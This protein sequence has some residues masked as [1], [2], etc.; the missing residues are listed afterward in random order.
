MGTASLSLLYQILLTSDL[1]NGLQ[2]DAFRLFLGV[3]CFM[4]FFVICFE[5]GS[6]LYILHKHFEMVIYYKEHSKYCFTIPT[7]NGLY[8][9]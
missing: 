4:Y 2:I 3:P 6:R 7:A 8:C 1:L 9:F 5:D